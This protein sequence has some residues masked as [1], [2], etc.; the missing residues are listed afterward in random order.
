MLLTDLKNNSKFSAIPAEGYIYATFYGKV[1]FE[2]YKKTAKGIE[3][4]G[5]SSLENETIQELHCFD[6]NTEYRIVDEIEAVMTYDEEKSMDK[7]L[8]Y[9]DEM[10]IDEKY[11]KDGFPSVLKIVNRYKYTYFDTLMLDNYRMKIES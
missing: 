2:K 10:L 9:E 11:L 6:E 4:A 5:S 8:L 1:I 7:D 3:F